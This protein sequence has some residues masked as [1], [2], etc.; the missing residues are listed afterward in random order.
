M[1]RRGEVT[2]HTDWCTT[3]D[4]GALINPQNLKPR[5][6]GVPVSQGH[7]YNPRLVGMGFLVRFNQGNPGSG[8]TPCPSQH[9]TGYYTL[10]SIF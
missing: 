6:G 3:P 2:Q 1:K 10:L 5:A 8:S 4:L 7:V 9:D